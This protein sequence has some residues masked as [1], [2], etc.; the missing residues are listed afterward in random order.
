MSTRE[1]I[2]SVLDMLT[3]DQLLELLSKAKNFLTPNNETLKAF[4]ETEYISNHPGEFK[5]FKK[6]LRIY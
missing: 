3:E 6:C 5:T 2:I 4:E 1:T